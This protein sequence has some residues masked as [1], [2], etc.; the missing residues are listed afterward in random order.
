MS[1]LNGC[2][3]EPDKINILTINAFADIFN[4]V[5]NTTY[6]DKNKMLLGLGDRG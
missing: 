3:N 6:H 1:F 5:R 2:K 4:K